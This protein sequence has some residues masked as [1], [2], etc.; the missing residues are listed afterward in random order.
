MEQFEFT[1]RY[2][3]RQASYVLNE[4]GCAAELVF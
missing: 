2:N 4:R 3:V 1:I